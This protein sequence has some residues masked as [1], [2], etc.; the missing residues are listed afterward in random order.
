MPMDSVGSARRHAALSTD[1]SQPDHYEIL[2]AALAE[3]REARVEAIYRGTC[4]ASPDL[5]N[6]LGP[7]PGRAVWSTLAL[8]IDERA[9]APPPVP[10]RS[11][12]L[13]EQHLARCLEPEHVSADRLIAAADGLP[14]LA[15]DDA[16]PATNGTTSKPEPSNMAEAS[17]C[18][19]PKGL[20]PGE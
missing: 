9:A 12:S 16:G 6:E 18:R 13:V 3:R 15:A 8:R 14:V 11:M 19:G 7:G 20:G 10:Q 17:H 1:A 5:T 4:P 2:R